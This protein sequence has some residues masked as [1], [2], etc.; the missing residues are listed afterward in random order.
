MT[1]RKS[2]TVTVPGMGGRIVELVKV[3][4][5]YEKGKKSDAL[6]AVT[7]S[8][9]HYLHSRKRLE[10]EGEKEGSGDARYQA[11]IRLRETYETAGAV[12]ARAIDY[13]RVKVDTSFRWGGTPVGQMQALRELGEARKF[14]GDRRFGVLQAVVCDEINFLDWLRTVD[15]EPSRRVRLWGYQHLRSGLDRLVEFYGVAVGPERARR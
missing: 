7:V 1:R 13:T 12:G 15:P 10:A 8:P 11:G 4:D 5:P 3:D 14:I 2:P 9:L 6:K